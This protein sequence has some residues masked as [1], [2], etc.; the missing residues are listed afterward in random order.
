MRNPLLF[1]DCSEKPEQYI[2]LLYWGGFRKIH[3]DDILSQ[4]RSG[5]WYKS[6]IYFLIY[7]EFHWLFLKLCIWLWSSII[8]GTSCFLEVSFNSLSNAI[9]VG[10]KIVHPITSILRWNKFVY[11]HE[12]KGTPGLFDGAIHTQQKGTTF[13]SGCKILMYSETILSCQ[14]WKQ[15]FISIG[16]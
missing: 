14:H 12:I 11:N 13:E 7:S 9:A 16:D 1:A 5:R 15:C 10:E 2:S 6:K 3:Y 4:L 8:T